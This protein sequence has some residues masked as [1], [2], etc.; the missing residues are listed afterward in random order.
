MKGVKNLFT[1]R[2][3]KYGTFATLIAVGFVAAVVIINIISSL[4]VDRFP[5]SVDLTKNKIFEVSDQTKEFLNTLNTDVEIMVLAEKKDFLN[6][7]EYHAQA[8]TV[9]DTYGKLS[10]R[11]KISY[12]N[13]VND[14]TLASKYPDLQLTTGD[15]LIRTDKR[16]RKIAASDLFN[17]EINQYTYQQSITSSKAEQTLTSALAA[18]T[19]NESVLVTLISGHDEEESSGLS[20]I[21]SSNSYDTATVKLVSEDIKKES[22]FVVI[23]NPK[24]DFTADELKK[25]DVFL[26]NDG[27]LGKTLLYFAGSEQPA[28]PNLEGFLKEWGI[29]VGTGIVYESDNNML[30]SNNYFATSA[31]YSTTDYAGNLASRNLL[32]G[33]PNGR[34]LKQVYE[35]KGSITTTKLLS[36][37][38][39]SRL[40]PADAPENYQ[41]DPN[42]DAQ[43]PFA[44]VIRAQ[45]QAYINNEPQNSN[46]IVFS[47]SVAID[48]Q[49]TSQSVVGNGEY[50]A[51]MLND[52]SEKKNAISIVP[53]EIG[54]S[55]LQINGAQM[56][57]IGLVFVILL[58]L[59][60]LVCGI[61]IWIKRRNR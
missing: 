42:K 24:R 41:L 53:K 16:T 8:I 48:E 39:G 36:Y 43:G 61:V 20:G 11:V 21:L 50:I 52:I 56:V 38:K 30:F 7:S 29:E 12:V 14:P 28:L 1:N 9:L 19:S 51:G 23:N 31:E 35:T 57:I 46:V 32:V 33:M 58:P 4:L 45:K 55:Q 18:V 10:N 54:T 22:K 13:L 2:R 3:F 15:I 6:A 44:A 27:K 47:T 60:I 40:R 59:A 17:T 5:L 25:L 34:P 49:L 26:S 37:S